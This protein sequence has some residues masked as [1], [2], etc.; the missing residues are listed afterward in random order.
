MT[1]A[2]PISIA[3]RL[4]VLVAVA[5]VVIPLRSAPIDAS[6]ANRIATS[7]LGTTV[8]ECVTAAR[9][10]RAPGA[11]LPY[12]VFN[13]AA[14]R[15]GY[16]IVAGD[17]RVPAVLAYSATGRFD[18][19]A[20]PAAMQD[21]LDDYAEQMAALDL[22]PAPS[23]HSAVARAAIAPMVTAH[24]GQGSPYNHLLPFE[25]GARAVTGCVATAMA[26]V[27]HYYQWPAKSTKAIPAYTTSG[28]I[29]MPELAV[30]S[31][32][33]NTMK[34]F[35]H[36]GDTTSAAGNAVATLMLYCGQA[37]GMNF[38]SST[39]SAATNK[40]PFALST[41]F[42]YKASSQY[43][44]RSSYTADDWEQLL[45][46][47]LAAGRP[48]VYAGN[49][50]SAGHALVCDGCDNEGRFHINWGWNSQS[51]GYFVLNV[52]NPSAEGIGAAAGSYGYVYRQGMAIGIEPGTEASTPVLTSTNVN[53]STNTTTV[54]RSYSTSKFYVEVYSGCFYNMTSQPA[55]FSYGWGLFDANDN[56]LEKIYTLNVTDLKP[57]Y[58]VGSST[59]TRSLGFGANKTSGTYY[60]KPI[61][62]EYLKDNWV[63]CLGADVN[64]VKVVINSAT[65]CAITG[66]GSM[67]TP[68]YSVD[69]VTCQGTLRAGKPVNVALTLTNNGHSLNDLVYLY[70]DGT[71][72]A[73]AL[74]TLNQGETGALTYRYTPTEAKTYTL[75]FS[76]NDDGSDP[77]A[78]HTL[79][80]DAMP[81]ASLA[82]TA[83][84][85]NVIDAE[86]RIVEGS[87]FSV[88]A[89]IENTG[90]NDYDEDFAMRLYRVTNL[91]SVT[92]TTVRT[93]SVP[94]QLA[95][96][97]TTTLRF[98]FD[99]LIDG[100]KYFAWLYYYSAGT[101]TTACG[102]R[103]YTFV[104]RD[105]TQGDEYA[106]GDVNADG[107]V[108][109]EDVNCLINIILNG[110]DPADYGNRADI[111]G[112]PGIDVGDVN[113][114]INIILG[115]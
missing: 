47:E 30:K 82:V 29:S 41:Y 42:G 113:A 56:L 40:V 97:Q 14:N 58:Y 86:Q 7:R 21:M 46:D 57:N 5:S 74:S 108:D 76:L 70:V 28:G 115:S 22:S 84:V 32:D 4:A 11:A 69:G 79:T 31:F 59:T 10:Q 81:E 33:W 61:C 52:L 68:D 13:A 112:T 25:N 88:L 96:G 99:D 12:Y 48:V 114:V 71:F 53:L 38:K 92:G 107:T 65:E 72:A 85:L 24:W 60:L 83:Q 26:Q 20:V 101:L 90:T 1:I 44:R 15:P 87:G 37:V 110:T 105:T 8:T 94:L 77:I 27:M 67:A 62:T 89:T 73:T 93:L 43:V 51:D 39:S 109:I 102:T 66:Y 49:K 2:N 103:A 63:P 98:D 55:S 45:Y 50:K 95:A 78:T 54:T 34:T 9:A 80:I 19:D 16:V 111:D 100:A 6:L 75:T 35:Y 91:E 18:S 17:D 36:Q 3:K 104:W 64:Y 23:V 106:L